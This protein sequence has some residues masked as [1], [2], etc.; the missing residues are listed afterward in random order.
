M[1]Y[2]YINWEEMVEQ[3]KQQYDDED[4]I[5]EFIDS[6]VPVYYHDILKAFSA[7]AE[8]ITGDDMGL[9]IWQVMTKHIYESYYNS[10]MNK[11]DGFDEEE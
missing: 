1:M 2:T 4:G 7:W 8:L 6:L 10:F 9:P 11:W 3:Y 5:H